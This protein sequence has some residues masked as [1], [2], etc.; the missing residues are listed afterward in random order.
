M[1]NC[2][3]IEKQEIQRIYEKGQLTPDDIA[4]ILKFIAKHQVAQSMQ[5]MLYEYKASLKEQ[6]RELSSHL[7]IDTQNEFLASLFSFFLP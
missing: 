3:E 6:T 7:G 5:L 4:I 2:S 1:Q